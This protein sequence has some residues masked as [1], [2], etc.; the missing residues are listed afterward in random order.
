MQTKEFPQLYAHASTG[1]TK[2]WTV[3]VEEQPDG[4]AD[5]ITE[6]GQLGGKLQT[7]VK[8]IASGKNLGKANETTPWEQAVFD[9]GSDFRKK[10]DK[11]YT[12]TLPDEN[13]EAKPNLLPM[14]ALDFRKRSHDIIYPAH[15]Q[16]KL[17]GVRC[18]AQKINQNVIQFTTRKCK[19]YP[20]GVTAHLVKPL[21]NLMEIGE[22][23][24]GEFY[25]HD[26]SFQKIAQTVKKVRP[27][28]SE[29]QFHI[30]DVANSTQTWR[31][32]DER[33]AGAWRQHGMQAGALTFVPGAL[34]IAEDQVK[35]WHDMYVKNGYEGIMVRNVA[36][37]YV[38]DHRTKDLQKYK[39]FIDEEFKIVGMREPEVIIDP[40]T[41]EE[42]KLVVFDCFSPYVPEKADDKFKTFGVRPKG[43]V[44]DRAQMFREID[45]LIGKMM[46]VRYQEL[47]VASED[48]PGG[49]PIFPVGITIRDYE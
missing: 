45:T 20:E 27:W 23:F 13:G 1:K 34:V 10:Q 33:L 19:D 38:F 43:T 16:P 14:L 47:S 36:G 28:A 21:L 24:D 3:R 2:T 5:I 9:A 35:V 12:E 44:V 42:V 6:Y 30:F 39:E 31:E 26:W 40:A 15:V 17:N 18:L 11:N 7:Q 46:T 22:I 25:V 48:K 29:L 37:L 8:H 32:R 41:R 4:T 49:L